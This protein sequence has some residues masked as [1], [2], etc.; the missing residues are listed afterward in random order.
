MTVMSLMY[1]TQNKVVNMTFRPA[2]KTIYFNII[3][4]LYAYVHTL[5]KRIINE[6]GTRVPI[7][8]P[9]SKSITADVLL[10]IGSA[11]FA[12]NNKCSHPCW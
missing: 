11:A 2:F 6:L 8:K 7:R 5:F 10:T 4:T 12:V 9:Q 1:N 3:Y